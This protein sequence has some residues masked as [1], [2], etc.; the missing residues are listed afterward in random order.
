MTR[1]QPKSA[2]SREELRSDAPQLRGGGKEGYG[3]SQPEWHCLGP[4]PQDGGSPAAAYCDYTAQQGKA[5]SAANTRNAYSSQLYCIYE[6]RRCRSAVVSRYRSCGK[7][8][9]S[10]P[11][12]TKSQLR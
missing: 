8:T 3:I 11:Q 5:H 1:H 7:H 12:S 6:W 4:I 2:H 10:L 9:Q